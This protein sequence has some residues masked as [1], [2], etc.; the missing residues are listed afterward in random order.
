M[1]GIII[2]NLFPQANIIGTI[3]KTKVL[4]SSPFKKGGLRGI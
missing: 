2:A 4:L 1:K 3:T